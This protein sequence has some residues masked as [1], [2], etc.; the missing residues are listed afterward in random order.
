MIT[1]QQQDRLYNKAKGSICSFKVAAIGLNKKGEVVGYSVNKPRFIRKG[2]GI[3]AEMC[4]MAR[5]GDNIKTIII[6]RLGN[7]YD[8]L[9]IQPC[10]MCKNK[11]KELGIKIYTIIECS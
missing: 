3:H 6:C 9:P 11:A 5:Y 7:N 4:L 8:Y 2:G 10:E 1:K